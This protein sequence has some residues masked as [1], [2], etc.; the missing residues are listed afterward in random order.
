MMSM[1]PLE[2]RGRAP[3]TE[4]PEE[5]TLDAT[6]E[7]DYGPMPPNASQPMSVNLKV[8]GRG[9]PLPFPLDNDPQD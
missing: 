3:I 9:K 2:P 5:P 4:A 8:R 7:L 1:M 6:A